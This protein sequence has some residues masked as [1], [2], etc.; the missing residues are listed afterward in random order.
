MR[1]HR[2]GTRPLLGQFIA[3]EEMWE[4]CAFW[5]GDKCTEVSGGEGTAWVQPDQWPDGS[6]RLLSGRP[7]RAGMGLLL[8]SGA[9]GGL[10]PLRRGDR[11]TAGGGAVRWR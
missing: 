7:R 4:I 3:R 2:S 10:G 11:Q 9:A 8:R 1:D 6:P 5:K